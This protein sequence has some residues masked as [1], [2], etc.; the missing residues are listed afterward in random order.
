MVVNDKLA[1]LKDMNPILEMAGDIP[2]YLFP[3]A[4]FWFVPGKDALEAL[5]RFWD[6]QPKEV[7][8]S[9]QRTLES[10]AR[11]ITPPTLPPHTGRK[12]LPIDQLSE[13]WFHLLDACNLSCKHCLF[14]CKP[15]SQGNDA[16]ARFIET[17][18]IEA[19]GEAVE[20]GCRLICFTGGEPFLYPGFVDLLERLQK[21][22][23]LRIAV[24]TNGT[25]ILKHI[26]ALARLDA[27]RLHFQVSLDGPQTMN[28]SLRGAGTFNKVSSGIFALKENKIPCSTVMAVSAENYKVMKEFV[29][30]SHSM[31][32]DNVHFMWHFPLGSGED[33]GVPPKDRLIPAF[34]DAVREAKK[35]GIVVDNME[36]VRAQVF[37]YPGTRFDLGNAGFESLCIGPDGSIYPS[38]ASVG[39]DHLNAGN[40][41]DGLAEVW[42]KSPV[43]E[44]LR[45]STLLDIPETAQDPWRLMLG[46][47]DLDHSLLHS[48]GSGEFRLKADPY[49]PLYREIALK[50]IEEEASAL[51]EPTGA[52]LRLRMGDITSECPSNAEV[53]FT[54]NNCLLSLGE[55][56]TRGLVRAFY[57]TRA[58]EPDEK[59]L[60]P[61]PLPEDAVDFIPEAGRVRMYG[62]GSPVA[63]AALRP[64]ETLVD[65]GSGSGVEC[66]MASRSVGP[67]GRVIGVDMTDSMLEIAERS[68]KEVEQKLGYSN[69]EF[70]KG[71][72]E[73]LPVE[74]NIADVVISNCVVNLCHN[75]RRVFNEILR[76]LK[77]GGR[78]VISDVV[79]E[80][81]PP[82]AI[83]ADNQLTG[84]CISGA[85]TQDY[86]FAMLRE[87]GFNATRIISRFPYRVVQG[88]PYFSLTFTAYKPSDAVTETGLHVYGGPFQRV[89]LDDGT[90]LEKGVPTTVALSPDLDEE[91]L[92]TM[93]VYRL[94]PRTGAIE[95]SDMGAS[96][97]CS[98]PTDV[99][100]LTGEACC[101]GSTNKTLS[102]SSKGTESCGCSAPETATTPPASSCCGQDTLAEL[103]KAS[104]TSACSTVTGKSAADG[105]GGCNCAP[106]ATDAH[107]AGCLVCGKP[108]VYNDLPEERACAKCGRVLAAD[109]WCSAGH[110]VCDLCHKG[111][112]LEVIRHV[113]LTSKETELFTM[114]DEIRAHPSF[115]LHGPEHHALVT[116]VILATYR[117]LGGDVNTLQ[118]MSG[119]DRAAIVPG[120]ACGFMG[121]CG[122]AIGVG[123]AFA[124]LLG[125]NPLR[126]DARRL[127]QKA[128]ARALGRIS[129]LEA[130]RCCRRECYVALEVAAE[131]SRELLSIP[132]QAGARPVCDQQDKN[133][134][135][136]GAD[137]PFFA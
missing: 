15:G 89:E 93:G 135:C 128:T 83:R 25:L 9:D 122:A 45:R 64:G 14:S 41:S 102:P 85:L 130:A 74:E 96:C 53:N 66:F 78:L 23:D 5:E 65:L 13:L 132:L 118:L 117:N 20:L 95:N 137:C 19:A 91:M 21:Y 10:L 136:I 29:I 12:E 52:G 125:S 84:E 90:V 57:G 59:I 38:P 106:E 31:D 77:P 67:T 108:L 49:L 114:L 70:I 134:E 39:Q 80:K 107:E 103:L 113:C 43:L 116:G 131:L 58:E 105:A 4:P 61:V 99:T 11:S 47:G 40:V 123:V 51:P 69:T 3:N 124:S 68:Q 133:K 112:P 35:H 63:D 56:G 2:V 98:V 36:A 37:T 28:D 104:G 18:V 75:K 16:R 24:L 119:I 30:A 62:C 126:A 120:G 100:A 111:D 6:P 109:A 76:I 73:E 48:H 44:K 88:H 22:P 55:G 26:D 81:E 34:F 1:F 32:V 110:F 33:M 54:H 46:G 8:S 129:D 92:G 72:L 27:S 94:N 60:N 50:L 121:S 86:L 115:P 127:S 7:R 97:C 79:C 71:F 101:E 82:L 87:T 17:N 42:K